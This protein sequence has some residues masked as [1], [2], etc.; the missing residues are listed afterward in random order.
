MK[1]I[2]TECEIVLELFDLGKFQNTSELFVPGCL[3]TQEQM[4]LTKLLK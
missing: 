1:P 4:G 3:S 2:I